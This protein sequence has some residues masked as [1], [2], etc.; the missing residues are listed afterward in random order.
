MEKSEAGD[1]GE[2]ARV[3]RL[4]A[5]VRHLMLSAENERA[6]LARQL[7]DE[8]GACLTVASLDI[9]VVNEKLKH[10]EPELALRLQRALAKIKEAVAMKRT[11]IEGLRPGML[12]SFGLA[13]CLDDYAREFG[14][15]TGVPVALDMVEEFDGMAP[16][17]AIDIFRVAQETLASVEKQGG[18]AGLKISLKAGSDAVCLL[19]EADGADLT[20]GIDPLAMSAMQERMASH[21]GSVVL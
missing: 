2:T 19:I 18:T 5:L 15:R 13:T 14:G 1:S 8:F 20:K 9:S 4:T 12:D 6:A 10:S 11:V 16:G 7:H 17:R 21:G 3:D